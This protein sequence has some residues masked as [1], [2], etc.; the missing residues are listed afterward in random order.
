MN[1]L[2][3]LA[4]GLYRNAI[5]TLG[6]VGVGL[7]L[8]LIL[9]GLPR[10]AQAAS[11]YAGNAFFSI[12]PYSQM[13]TVVDELTINQLQTGYNVAGQFKVT[14][15]AGTV[16]GT[17]LH[18]QVKRL[19]NPNFGF[20]W[21]YLQQFVVGFSQP[22]GG[23]TFSPTS[24][25]AK[26]Y[27]DVTGWPANT[28]L[29]LVNG[30]ATWNVNQIGNTFNYVSGTDVYLVQDFELDGSKLTGPGGTW[31][32]D[33]PLSSEIIFVPEP[34]SAALFALGLAGLGRRGGRSQRKS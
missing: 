13:G 9:V 21:M 31:I 34:G 12:A 15:P 27:L 30:A 6:P 32:I 11:L 28:P 17:L 20:Q 33:L 5:Q 14:V 25:Y 10:P 24:G 26:T 2:H 19:L 22:T 7:L 3:V 8:P 4:V 23:G 18:Y 1:R 29:N 16:S